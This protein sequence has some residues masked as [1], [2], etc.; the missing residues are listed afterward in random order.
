MEFL[1]AVLGYGLNICDLRVW[2]DMKLL[3]VGG[4]E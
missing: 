1:M 3:V 4:G 2:S